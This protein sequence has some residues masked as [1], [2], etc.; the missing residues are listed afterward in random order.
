MIPK[1]SQLEIERRWLV[2]LSR[3]DLDCL[4]E[5]EI[6]EDRYLVGTRLRLRK[7]SGP[8]GDVFKFVKKYGRSGWAEPITNLYLDQGEYDVIA[9]LPARCVRKSRFRLDGGSLDLFGEFAIFEKEFPSI[10][11]AEDYQPG[12]FVVREL[13]E[14]E[15]TGAQIAS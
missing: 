9:S 10:E 11:A 2:D 4:G 5:P 14:S 6:I 3:I 7:M 8:K 13:G 12:A 15:L 1:Y